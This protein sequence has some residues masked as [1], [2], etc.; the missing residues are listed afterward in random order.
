VRLCTIVYATHI[1]DNLAQWPSHLVHMHL[2][3]VK[4]WG[5]MDLFSADIPHR[6]P[7][8]S[9]LGDLVLHW[10]KQDFEARGPRKGQPNEGKTYASLEG[11]GGYGLEKAPEAQ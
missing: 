1:L 7:E 10:L 5:P 2:G 8:N 9:R 3:Q 11:K 4:Q 6:V